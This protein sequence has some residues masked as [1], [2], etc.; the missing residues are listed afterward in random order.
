MCAFYE[1][2]KKCSECTATLFILLY[3]IHAESN[4]KGIY[5]KICDN[6]KAGGGGL[7]TFGKID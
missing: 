2:I 6:A 3:R 7:R 5:Q 4:K 1:I